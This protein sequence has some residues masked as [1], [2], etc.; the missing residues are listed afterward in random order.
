M[1]KII[2]SVGPYI[3]PAAGA[4]ILAAIVAYLAG[5]NN[6]RSRFHLVSDDFYRS[7]LDAIALFSDQDATTGLYEYLETSF[8][9][10]KKAILAFR[11]NL[12][13]FRRRGLDK[14]WNSYRYD[15]NKKYP[16]P[17]KELSIP[18]LSEFA[19]QFQWD[20]ETR[21]KTKEVVLAKIQRIVRYARQ[22]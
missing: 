17:D 12:G 19:D 16:P 15:I 13:F 10:H 1:D 20:V 8:P 2:N 3:L 18:I 5:L 4:L 14:A 21:E 6:R 22:K 9:A 11:N 7:F